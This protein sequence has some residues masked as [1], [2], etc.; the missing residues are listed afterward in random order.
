MRV[1]GLNS[2]SFKGLAV[3][4]P[5][6]VITDA[7]DAIE[8]W[9]VLKHPKYTE[10]WQEDEEPSFELVKKNQEIRD[11]NY[12]FLDCLKNDKE[13]SKFI[14]N[15]KKITGFPVLSEISK[16]M[17]DEFNRTL[18]TACLL[19]GKQPN[20]VL[21]SGYDSFC[22]VGL[23]NPLP[24]SDID[25]AY[26]VVRGIDSNYYSDQKDYS[27]K[28][29][30]AIWDTIDSRIVSVNHCAAF[31]NIVTD[32]ELTALLNRYSTF[33]DK[34]ADTDNIRNLFLNERMNNSNTVS[35][36]KFNIWLSDILPSKE[37]KNEAKNLAYVVET[38]RDCERNIVDYGY[39]QNLCK[40]LNN[41]SFAWF[42]NVCQN[43]P[44]Q[45]KYEYS[46]DK[47]TKPKLKARKEME[48]NFDSMSID[49][50]YELVKD[51]IRSM[52]GDNKNPE[53][54][55]LFY[56][57]TDKHRLLLNDILKGNVS[58][59][60]DFPPEVKERIHLFFNTMKALERYY[61]IDVYSKNR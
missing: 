21:L 6:R 52:S 1:N 10:I 42:S 16:K 4:T 47:E 24:G 2:V 29:M 37:A 54:Q 46:S 56:S 41:S 35:S 3:R 38:I 40:E 15:Y 12:S 17:L 32:K 58:C 34:I 45:K 18:K 61:D 27:A 25:K 5:K 44:M 39:F 30:G 33:G 7:E 59:A 48:K 28:F 31:P 60:F 49:K 8:Q 14:E 9:N 53:F 19:M 57:K 23:G 50:Q 36:A 55:D 22:S 20:D 11:E 13:K 26:A 51:V 43:Y